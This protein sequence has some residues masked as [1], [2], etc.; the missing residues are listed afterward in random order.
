MTVRVLNYEPDYDVV[1]QAIF[2]R[3]LRYFTLT[4]RDGEDGLDMFKGA[5]FSIGN[6][7]RFDLRVYRGHLNPNFTV[8]LYLPPDVKDESAVS[9]IIDRVV[10]EMVVPLTAVTWRRGQPFEYGKVERQKHDRLNET[11]ARTLVLKIAGSQPDRAATMSLL[12]DE[13]PK[14]V[15]LSPSDRIASKTRVREQLWHQIIR[16]VTSSHQK[17][18][19]GIYSQGYADKTK[20]GF[21]L[22]SK[23]MD[24]LNSIG[25]SESSASDLPAAE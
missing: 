19:R 9:V 11:E 22:T 21:K 3:P 6:D 20:A 13:V 8:T 5:S 24:Y 12:R 25:F 14:F 23:G 17:G 7:I 16:N 2:W 10:K 15:E 18:N 4:I 1:P